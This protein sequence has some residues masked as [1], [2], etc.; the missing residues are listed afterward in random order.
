MGKS[1]PTQKATILHCTWSLVQKPIREPSRRGSQQRRPAGRRWWQY[2]QW[3]SIYQQTA[4]P[5]GRREEH[6]FS[7]KVCHYLILV[8][9]IFQ[10]GCSYIDLNIGHSNVEKR[11]QI[12]EAPPVV[13]E[14]RIQTLHL[15]RDYKVAPDFWMFLDAKTNL[16]K[17]LNWFEW[18]ILCTP[19]TL[20]GWCYSANVMC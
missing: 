5:S 11:D 3:C 6:K 20:D 18:T 1:N 12:G 13:W 17:Q 2:W 4:P 9:L 8:L 7:W 16:D 15:H 19:R 10:S 14:Q